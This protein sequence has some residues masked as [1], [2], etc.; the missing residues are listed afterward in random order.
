M[1][2]NGPFAVNA[3]INRAQRSP[4]QSTLPGDPSILRGNPVATDLR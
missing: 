4:A 1:Q 3:K 2:L